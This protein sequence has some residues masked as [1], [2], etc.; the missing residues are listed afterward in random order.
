VKK[1]KQ[2]NQEAESKFRLLRG[3]NL[4]EY[5]KL[6]HEFDLLIRRKLTLYTLK[7][8]RRKRF[9]FSEPPN[10]LGGSR[11]KLDFILMYLKENPNQHYHAHLFGMCQSKV[12]EWVSFILPV[13]EEAL[14]KLSFMPQSGTHFV[15]DK[16]D[17]DLLIDVTERI[18]PRRTD[19]EAQK[20]EY[21][22]KK[23]MHTIKNL[24]VTNNCGII[25]FIS[26]SYFGKMHDKAIWDNIE[27]QFNDSTLFVDLGFKGVEKE[28]VN[29]RIPHKKSKLK[30]L[31]YGQKRENKEIGRKRITV[32]HAFGG[33]KILKIIRD[34]IR[35]KFY[36]K[37]DQVFRIA[38]AL[39]NLR[40]I[41]RKPILN[42]S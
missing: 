6:L 7:V 39:H 26:E 37:R 2:R 24:A 18:V 10:S 4:V 15:A 34:K 14:K 19:H 23:K 11:K 29:V 1:I 13:L 3:L 41:M 16:S 21:S 9:M 17:S 30:E 12:S 28:Y 33:V 38:S 5:E 31:N 22:G 36:E 35:L 20:E 27:F 42:E 32:E 8:K 40:L 25:R